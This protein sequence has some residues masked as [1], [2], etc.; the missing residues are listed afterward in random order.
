MRFYVRLRIFIVTEPI[1]G[2]KNEK[3][4]KEEERK[5]KKTDKKTERLM[6]R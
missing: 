1:R 2:E 6:K 5:G 3:K 4:G